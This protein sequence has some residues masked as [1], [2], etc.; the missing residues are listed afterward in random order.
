MSKVVNYADRV[1]M[2]AWTATLLGFY[3]FLR[4]SNLV[5]DTM[6]T[7]NVEQQFCRGDINLLGMDKAMMIEIRWSKTIQH[8]QKILRLPVLPAHNKAVCPVF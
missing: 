2:V 4:K 6:D 8:K 3:L 1:E 5:P 7:Y